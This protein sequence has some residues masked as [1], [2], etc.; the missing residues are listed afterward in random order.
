M[1]DPTAKVAVHLSAAAAIVLLDWLNTTD[2]NQVPVVDRAQT[3][4]V[5]GLLAAL[6]T[7]TLAPD[8]TEEDVRTALAVI[9]ADIGWTDPN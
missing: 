9:G 4:A 8:A 5:L 2:L 1:D 3:Q 7:D 6:E